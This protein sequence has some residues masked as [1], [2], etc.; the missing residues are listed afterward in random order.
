MADRYDS[1]TRKAR[2]EQLRTRLWSDRSSFDSHW[3]ELADFLQP[4]RT[5]FFANDRNRGDKRSQK[6][7]DSTA[8][9][10]FRTLQSGLHAGLTSPARPWF[11]LT[12]PDPDLAESA[13]VKQW[14]HIVTQR[15]A[16]VFVQ[17]NLY[18]VLPTVY[19]DMGGFG[20]GVMAVIDDDK[21]LMRCFSYPIGSY[22]LGMDA[23]GIVCTFVR[24][25]QLSVR[26]VV[27]TFGVQPNRDIDWR[28]ISAHVK[29]LWERAQYEEPINVTWIVTPNEE[30]RA[31]RLGAK[32]LPFASCHFEQ[33][34]D[35]DMFLKE[36]GF[37]SNPILAPRWD[38]TGEDTY[39]T[40]CP[41]MTALGDV[42]QLQ[43]MQRKKAQAIAKMV[44]PPLVGPTALRQQKTSLHPGE[45]TY[46][47]TREGMAGL[48]A[49]HEIGLN[50]QHL[51][52]DI[53]ETQYR[54]QRAFYEDLF[55]M[56]ARS[57]AQRG[58]QPATARE[59]EERHEEKLLALG[60]VL[61]RTDDELLDP[62]IDRVY[63]MMERGGMIPPAPP[64][65]Q[66]VDLKVEYISIMAQAQ[67]L[68]GVVGQDRFLQTMV[69]LA[70][71]FPEVRHKID[72]MRIVDNYGD[73]L[74]LDPRTIIPT[75]QARA[76]VAAQAQREQQLQDAQQAEMISK[77]AKNAGTTPMDGDTALSRVVGN[78]SP[79]P[80]QPAGVA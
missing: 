60:P 73:M 12:T 11:R 20:T 55:L 42:K 50:L 28:N 48:R 41:G 24:D 79:S 39:G 3:Q 69:P 2:Y 29:N 52:A 78:L 13:A 33:G 68:V 40:D 14:L 36:S 58:T 45:V 76:S 8:R 35:R 5:R 26:Q 54:I 71:Q 18:N 4:R 62:L 80:V 23:R 70:E 75:D 22:A 74:G 77:A 66:G 49:I 10:S 72:V 57:D 21:E 16:I 43:T 65:L 25:Y 1:T 6:I 32:Y 27:E 61:E 67:K 63:S 51:V 7:I 37:R 15:M 46:V 19:G 34:A 38:I 17:S 59:I 53:G 64:E 9:F 31:D 30:A 47:D 56:L 44:D